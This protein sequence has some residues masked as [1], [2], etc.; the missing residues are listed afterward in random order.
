MNKENEKDFNVLNV[1]C[2]CGED[3]E[4]EQDVVELIDEHGKPVRF[5]II[6]N[7]EVDDQEYAILAN[8]SDEEDVIIFRV[9]EE[10]EEFVFETIEDQE[11]LD[12]V[13]EA[14]GELLEELEEDEE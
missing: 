6:A 4:L 11:E 3:H 13:V 10:D 9:T 2:G 5:V 7:L 8:E 12:A 14:Y 1:G